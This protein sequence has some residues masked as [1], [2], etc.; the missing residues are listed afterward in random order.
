MLQLDSKGKIKGTNE[1]Y[2]SKVV[3][4]KRFSSYGIIRKPGDI[5][6]LE[7]GVLIDCLQ[8]GLVRRYDPAVDDKK[9]V[10]DSTQTLTEKPKRKRRKKTESD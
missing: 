7:G 6:D 1:F 9:E 5:M 2:K 4:L 3:V 8:R 10:S